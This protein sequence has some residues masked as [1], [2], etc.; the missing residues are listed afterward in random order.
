MKTTSEKGTPSTIKALQ[1]IRDFNITHARQFASLM[2]PDSDGWTTHTRCGNNGVSHGGG[3]NL[4]GGAYIGKLRQ[5][6]LVFGAGGGRRICLTEEG[7]TLLAT[8]ASSKGS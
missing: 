5:R 8:C 6:G 4:A 7:R 2:W 3:M 1:I